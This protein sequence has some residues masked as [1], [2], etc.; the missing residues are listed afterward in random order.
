MINARGI[1]IT[2]IK[3]RYKMIK[4]TRRSMQNYQGLKRIK[5]RG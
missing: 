2:G 5:N 1:R 3:E 4:E